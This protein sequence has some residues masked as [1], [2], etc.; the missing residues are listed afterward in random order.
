MRIE[1]D[2][3]ITLSVIAA[4]GAAFTLAA[5]LPARAESRG[6]TERI[7][8]ARAT[9][10]P[11]MQADVLAASDRAVRELQTRLGEQERFVPEAPELASVLRSLTR[12]VRDRGVQEHELETL[13]TAR[14]DRYSVIP[15][16]LAFH[17]EF[18]Q[19]FDVLTDIESMPRLIRVDRLA[20]RADRDGD[21]LNP[22]LD[23]S[24]QLSTFHASSPGG[25]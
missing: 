7:E 23:A 12:A 25:E 13:E 15:A 17:A 9:L 4:M 3:I 10:G 20:L 16:R 8:A 14:Y 5:W 21:P 19:T 1:K 18:E 11:R 2:Q 22:T 6:Y 24:M